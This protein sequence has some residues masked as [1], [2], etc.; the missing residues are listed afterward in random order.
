MSKALELAAKLSAV[1]GSDLTDAKKLE[2][3]LHFGLCRWMHPVDGDPYVFW[4]ADRVTA[5]FN[6][7]E[8]AACAERDARIEYLTKDRDLEKKMR[9][10]ADERIAELEAQNKL[11]DSLMK[12]GEQRGVSKGIE[13]SAGRIAELERQLADARTEATA[14]RVNEQNLEQALEGMNTER[15]GAE[16]PTGA[17]SSTVRKTQDD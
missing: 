8:A 4:H 10:D 15:S 16:R 5:A 14:L 12:S 11:L 17:A 6:E 9:K 13:E 1:Y 7:V 3:A 2:I